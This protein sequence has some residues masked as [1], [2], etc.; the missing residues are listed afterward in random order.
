M[1]FGINDKIDY[2]TCT[3]CNLLV[4]GNK[5]RAFLEDGQP[6]G[7]VQCAERGHLGE[8]YS[9]DARNKG[10]K[11]SSKPINELNEMQRVMLRIKQDAKSTSEPGGC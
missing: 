1:S 3:A 4:I 5:A 9:N 7:Y 10:K 6:N 11:L 2:Y 8:Y